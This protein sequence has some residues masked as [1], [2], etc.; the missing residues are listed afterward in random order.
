[1]VLSVLRFTAS[2]YPL[3][4]FRLFFITIELYKKT[5]CIWLVNNQLR[6]DLI[7]WHIYWMIIL[8]LRQPDNYKLLNL[9]Y[10]LSVKKITTQWMSYTKTGIVYPSWAHG[11]NSCFLLG[12][13]A[14]FSVQDI[15]CVSSVF[16][17][18]YLTHLQSSKRTIN[19]KKNPAYFRFHSEY[20]IL[21]IVLL[22]I[23]VIL[24]SMAKCVI[25][26]FWLPTFCMAQ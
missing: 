12:R 21:C 26:L 20:H 9:K 2:D 13:I 7:H 14:H 4:T 23:I 19:I 8:S 11:F 5:Q 22:L 1:M 10:K 15:A 16:S 3:G 18:V 25:N 24:H 17:G 6:A